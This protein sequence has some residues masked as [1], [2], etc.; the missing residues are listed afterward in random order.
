MRARRELMKCRRELVRTDRAEWKDTLA[1]RSNRE[2]IFKMI[3]EAGLRLKLYL[4][5][6]GTVSAL[7]LLI[8]RSEASRIS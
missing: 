3:D 7:P 2:M 4:M 1:Q 6:L 8:L 5:I